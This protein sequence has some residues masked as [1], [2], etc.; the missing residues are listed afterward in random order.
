MPP[1]ATTSDAGFTL[2]ELMVVIALIGLISAAV[3]LAM[4]DPQRRLRGDAQGL[5]ARLV[6]AR[7]RA[8]IGGHDVAVRIDNAGYGFAER[9]A[10]GWQ[11]LTD[12][13]FADHGWPSGTDVA[14]AIE[15]DT[16]VFDSS[17]SA[18]PGTLRLR[19]DGGEARIAIDAAG[20]VHFNAQ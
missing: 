19:R 6:A 13:G 16:L 12:A 1:K 11:P 10:A 8:I 7:D 3:M 20:A 4:P 17:G 14:T 15:G 18:A 5:A 2:V 9:R